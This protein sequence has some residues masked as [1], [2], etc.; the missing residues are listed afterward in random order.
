MALLCTITALVKW[1]Q[2]L[3]LSANRQPAVMQLP[4]LQLNCCIHHGAMTLPFKLRW[5]TFMWSACLPLLSLSAAWH[6]LP[7]PCGC[8]SAVK[9]RAALCSAALCCHQETAWNSPVFWKMSHLKR[10]SSTFPALQASVW[11]SCCGCFWFT[12]QKI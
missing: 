11:R 8:V 10:E 3:Q 4:C 12:E 2:K 6:P 1:Q 7:V 9:Q 5:L